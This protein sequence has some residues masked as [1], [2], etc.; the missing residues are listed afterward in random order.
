MANTLRKVAR[1]GNS[2]LVAF[3]F[4]SHCTPETPHGEPPQNGVAQSRQTKSSASGSDTTAS[5][6]SPSVC[7]NACRKKFDD[8]AS[9]RDEWDTCVKACDGDDGCTGECDTEYSYNCAD[10]P[11]RCDAIDAC[12]GRCG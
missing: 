2:A 4:T 8:V 12:F 10:T 9:Y 3:V 5:A 11:D 7:R 1:I 6:T